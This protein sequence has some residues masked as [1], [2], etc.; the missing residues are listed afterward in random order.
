VTTS[1][2]DVVTAGAGATSPAFTTS[3]ASEVILAGQHNSGS[4]TAFT[5]SSGCTID[6]G[7]LPPGSAIGRPVEYCIVTTQQVSAT[8]GITPTGGNTPT[9]TNVVSFK[10]Q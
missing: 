10:G 9:Q 5:A 7:V 8:V 2:L 3:Q 1:P 4:S 6:V